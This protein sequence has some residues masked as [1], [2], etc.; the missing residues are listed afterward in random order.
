MR[1]HA[2]PSLVRAAR[3]IACRPSRPTPTPSVT[4]SLRRHEPGPVHREGAGA[5]RDA[6]DLTVHKQ[7]AILGT[8]IDHI[9]INLPD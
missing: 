4:R 8:V 2:T 5:L 7:R 6:G 1:S 3:R 9:T